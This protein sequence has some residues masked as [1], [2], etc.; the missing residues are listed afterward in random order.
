MVRI[1]KGAAP[2]VVELEVDDHP[3][4]VGRLHLLMLDPTPDAGEQSGSPE[5]IPSL[6]AAQEGAVMGTPLAVSYTYGGEPTMV[7]EFAAGTDPDMV[8]LPLR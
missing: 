8:N 7:R 2:E 4:D 1:F 3:A 5:P 6:A